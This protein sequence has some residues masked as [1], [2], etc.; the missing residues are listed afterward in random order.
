MLNIKTTAEPVRRYYIKPIG[1]PI[2]RIE[3]VGPMF[4]CE[5]CLEFDPCKTLP[6]T[7]AYR[8]KRNPVLFEDHP[9]ESRCC[10][11]CGKPIAKMSTPIHTFK[12]LL[13]MHIKHKHPEI[14]RKRS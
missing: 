4:G 11:H 8:Y 14:W 3:P 5:N 10:P 9:E 2:R 7:D 6:K 13:S 12:G 1:C